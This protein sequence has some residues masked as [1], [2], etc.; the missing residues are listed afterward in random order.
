MSETNNPQPSEPPV[1]GSGGGNVAEPSED[2]ENPEDAQISDP[3]TSGG[4]GGS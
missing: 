4:G 1:T 3:P 2:F